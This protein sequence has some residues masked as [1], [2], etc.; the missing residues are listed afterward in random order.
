MRRRSS[1]V[2]ELGR[3][4]GG[5]NSKYDGSED[6]NELGEL[7]NQQEGQCGYIRGSEGKCHQRQP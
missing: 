6:G 5:G 7:W 4:S 3:E 1:P 2:E